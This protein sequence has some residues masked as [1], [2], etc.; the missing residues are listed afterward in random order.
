MPRKDLYHKPVRTALENDGWTITADEYVVQY[1]GKQVYVDLA[2]EKVIV[3][4]KGKQQIAVEIKVFGT[5]SP[6]TEL[7]RAIGQYGIYRIFLRQTNPERQ[8]FLAIAVDIY[9]DFFTQPAIQEIV[10]EYQINL[11]VFDPE[12]AEV[13]QWIIK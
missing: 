4:E 7:E 10:D 5:P 9:Q 11:L 12:L 6:M 2:A 8:L 3:A 13:V 1:K